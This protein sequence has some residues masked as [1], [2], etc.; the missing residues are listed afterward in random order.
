MITCEQYDYLE[1]A[2]LFGY[3]V[4]VMLRNNQCVVG[5]TS[6]TQVNAH[7]QEE[8]VLLIDGH[9]RSVLIDDLVRLDVLTPNAKF[10]HVEF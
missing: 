9:T 1:M 4:R 10:N 3:Q 6:T 8:L 5:I 7:R 2:C